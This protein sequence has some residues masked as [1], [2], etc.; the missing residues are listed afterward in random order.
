MPIT[1]VDYRVTLQVTYGTPCYSVFH[2]RKDG[3]HL[4]GDAERLADAFDLQVVEHIAGIMNTGVTLN[5]I[6]VVN[7][8]DP[9]DYTTQGVTDTQG[10]VGTLSAGPR[11]LAYAFRLNRTR[12]DGRHGYKRFVGVAEDLVG[13]ESTSVTGALTTAI[14]LLVASLGATITNGGASFLP[15]IQHKEPVTL[16]DG[17]VTYIL[18]DL[19]NVG[20]VEFLGLT[21]QNTR[22]Q[23]R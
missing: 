7:L 8:V 20:P 19:F 5:S 4:A 23:N 1:S 16:P 6:E 12:R 21:T 17:S 18:T 2:Y 14:P 10:D 15:M 11:F 9:F 22:K 3:A 13:G